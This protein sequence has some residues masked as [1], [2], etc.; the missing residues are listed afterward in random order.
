MQWKN[1]HP[2]NIY[3]LLV[4]LAYFFFIISPLIWIIHSYTAWVWK[5]SKGLQVFKWTCP[6]HLWWDFCFP[7]CFCIHQIYKS[8]FTFFHAFLK[9]RLKPLLKCYLEQGSG[10]KDILW[11]LLLFW[12]YWYIITSQNSWVIS[13]SSITNLTVTTSWSSCHSFL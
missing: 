11:L 3:L 13:G 9:L 4:Y 6:H 1:G 2:K 5:F 7:K 8:V 12:S 10:G